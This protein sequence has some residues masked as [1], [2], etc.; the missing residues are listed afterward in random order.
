MERSRSLS[1][2]ATRQMIA[3]WLLAYMSALLAVPKEEIDESKTFERYGMDSSAAVA[4]AADLSEWLGYTVDPAITYDYSTIAGL[5]DE[6]STI[7]GVR[8]ALGRVLSA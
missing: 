4:L 7:E 8:S 6:L 3:A 5:A 1:S 2:D